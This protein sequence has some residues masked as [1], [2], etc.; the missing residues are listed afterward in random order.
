MNYYN[1]KIVFNLLG[2]SNAV[3]HAS[4]DIEKI[5]VKHN[6]YFTTFNFNRL[7]WRSTYHQEL[8]NYH[9]GI[10]CKCNYIECRELI[11][12]SNFIK[13]SSYNFTKPVNLVINDEFSYVDCKAVDDTYL[14]FD[15]WSKKEEKIE[16]YLLN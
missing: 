2:P 9:N 14:L 11:K 16:K 7:N 12:I 13:E 5:F 1:K 8:N 15:N 6:F 10:I 3:Y 4:K